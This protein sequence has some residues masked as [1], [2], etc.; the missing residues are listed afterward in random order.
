M[1]MQW[2]SERKA[3]MQPSS[4]DESFRTEAD[5]RLLLDFFPD[6]F[7]QELQETVDWVVRGGSDVAELEN[8]VSGI[9]SQENMQAR[10][11]STH[12]L[13]TVVCA[14]ALSQAPSVETW[15]NVR[16]LKNDSWQLE[17]WLAVAMDTYAASRIDARKAYI[18][19][20]TT[21]FQALDKGSLTSPRERINQERSQAWDSW[22]TRQ[23]KLD[24]IW[25]GLRGWN[26]LNYEEESPLFHVSSKLD[27]KEFINVLAGSTNPYLVRSTLLAT[28]AGGFSPDFSQWEKFTIAAP[29]AFE[30]DGKWNGSVLIP[31]LLVEAHAQ[32]IEAARDLPAFQ[33]GDEDV[34]RVKQVIA[35]EIEAVVSTLNTRSDALPIFSRW[36]TWLMRQLLT[37]PAKDI[38]DVRSVAFVDDAVIDAIGRTLKGKTVIPTSPTDASAWEAWSYRCVLA[39]HANGGFLD[40]Q[41]SSDFL[42]EWDISI[43]EWA[44]SNGL[45][46]RERANVVL[47]LDKDTPGVAANLLAYPIV[48]SES[49]TDGWLRLWERSQTLREVIEFGDA[50]ARDDEYQSR[51]EAGRLMLLVFRI[52]LAILDQCAYQCTNSDLPQAR[53]LAKLHTALAAAIREM[54]EID[55]TLNR[56]GWI[57]MERHLIVRRFIWEEEG[58]GNGDP[59]AVSIFHS[60]DAPTL[61]DYLMATKSDTPELLS[62]IQSIHL[63]TSSIS[64][65]HLELRSAAIDIFDVI[66]TVRKLNHYNARRYPVDEGQLRNLTQIFASLEHEKSAL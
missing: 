7:P 52:G 37:Y 29:S 14:V 65:L 45:R 27:P 62:L 35:K 56:D 46:L 12:L 55:S 51:S 48:H 66:E 58:A 8:R 21:V 32:L 25:W 28:G 31:L 2:S 42:A 39:S 38:V 6:G 50:D 57:A 5:F 41:D 24:E 33:A 40:P 44:G 36:T 13:M 1:N 18:D 43:D 61:K 64:R 10:S 49:P 59:N 9:P 53:A 60:H 34:P 19:L 54:R 15:I 63:N 47:S 3:A 26:F 22:I 4:A 30:K 11:D 20:A 23:D 16:A 17:H